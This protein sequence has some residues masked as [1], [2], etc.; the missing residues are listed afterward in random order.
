MAIF[1]ITFRGGVILEELIL[2]MSLSG[3]T[4]LRHIYSLGTIFCCML[5]A[6][7]QC[8]RKYTCP[9]G[10]TGKVYFQYIT[11]R[12]GLYMGCI[13]NLLWNLLGKGI[14]SYLTSGLFR[15]SHQEKLS[16]SGDIIKLED[17]KTKNSALQQ[18]YLTP[19]QTESLKVP[20]H[21][22]NRI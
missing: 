15:V 5:P 1:S 10:N 13:Q 7:V 4:I 12:N 22:P 3:R 18:E 11:F 2:R 20:D 14:D 6:E 8:P 19:C 21:S 9:R 17:L 16:I